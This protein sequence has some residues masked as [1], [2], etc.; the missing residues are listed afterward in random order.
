MKKIV[1]I[2]LLTFF[3]SNSYA[4]LYESE[5]LEPTIGCVAAGAVGVGSASSGNEAVQGGLYCLGGILIGVAINSYY[6]KRIFGLHESKINNK[7]NTILKYQSQQAQ[8][9]FDGKTDDTF[10]LDAIQNVD[11]QETTDGKILSPTKRI[12]LKAP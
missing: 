7:K 10:S 4:G 6:K 9:V 2:I 8:K 11:P 1:S 3:V 12:I 5:Y